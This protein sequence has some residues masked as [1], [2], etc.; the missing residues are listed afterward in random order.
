MSEKGSDT[1]LDVQSMKTAID[2]YKQAK[3]YNF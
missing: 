2:L 3:D 1:L